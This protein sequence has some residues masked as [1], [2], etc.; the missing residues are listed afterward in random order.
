MKSLSFFSSFFTDASKSETIHNSGWVNLLPG[1]SAFFTNPL[2]KNNDKNK[3][4]DN[5]KK[6]Q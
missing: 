3:K 2:E 5:K 4:N 6:L 1:A